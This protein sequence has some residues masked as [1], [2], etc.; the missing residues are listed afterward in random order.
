MAMDIRALFA[1]YGDKKLDGYNPLAA[2][3]KQYGAAGAGNA[4]NRGPVSAQGQRGYD[5]R[6][7]K[8][9]AQRNALLRRMQAEQK[10]AY[11]D[12]DV[13]RGRAR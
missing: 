4:P 6:T 11:A 8:A 9:N 10:G 1:Q 7:M 5:E 3:A 13:L 2:G 12:P